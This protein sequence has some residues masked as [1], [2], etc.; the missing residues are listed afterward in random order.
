VRVTPVIR[1][2]PL[3]TIILNDLTRGRRSEQ[4]V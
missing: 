4:H 1:R 3:H 2:L